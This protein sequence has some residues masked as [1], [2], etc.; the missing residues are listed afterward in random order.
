CIAEDAARA[1]GR[2]P[3]RGDWSARRATKWPVL[4]YSIGTAPRVASPRRRAYRLFDQR[5]DSEA[6][7]WQCRGDSPAPIRSPL[8]SFL[9]V[10]PAYR[11]IFPFRP[12][13]IRRPCC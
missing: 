5:E 6:R 11:A 12:A 8:R 1:T 4:E 9:E 7:P 13:T 3:H 2:I 10:A